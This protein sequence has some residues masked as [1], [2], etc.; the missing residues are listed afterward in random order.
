MLF[1]NGRYST[2]HN[3]LKGVCFLVQKH[4]LTQEKLERLAVELSDFVHFFFATK[5]LSGYRLTEKY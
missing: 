2:S 4:A 5:Y 1:K 3:P